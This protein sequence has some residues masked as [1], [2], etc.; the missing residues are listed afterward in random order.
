V[1][2][3]GQANSFLL[4]KVLIGC[5]RLVWELGSAFKK[6]RMA[7]LTEAVFVERR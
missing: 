2:G 3:F 5:K 7:N 1:T 6:T 4:A